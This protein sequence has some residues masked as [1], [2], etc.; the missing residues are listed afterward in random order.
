MTR[1]TVEI[2]NDLI[3]E[4]M[5]VLGVRTKKEGDLDKIRTSEA[6]QVPAR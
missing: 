6:E 1:T 4:A 3:A 5:R 2:D